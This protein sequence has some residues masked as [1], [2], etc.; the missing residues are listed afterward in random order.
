MG[1][2]TYSYSDRALRSSSLGY[3]TKSAQEIFVERNIN[4]AMNP[5]GVGIRESCDS[6]EHPNSLPI[7]IALDVTGSMGSVPH[8][9]VKEGFP[10]I[11]D[12]IIKSGI[13]DPQVLFL[14]IGDHEC[15]HAPLQVGQ[16]ESSDEL[17][18]K[19]LTSIYLEGGGGGNAGESYLLA[20]YFASY[21]T[22][23]DS[24]EKRGQKGFLFTIGDEPTLFSVPKTYLKK[25]MGEGQYEDYTSQKLLEKA[26]EKYNV[27]HIHIKETGA[28]SSRS[29]M[30]GWK[31][32]MGDEHLIIAN[33][34]EDVADI[35]KNIVIE[36]EAPNTTESKNTEPKDKKD[37]EMML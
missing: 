21:H 37:E 30:N 32:L 3:T 12:S 5:F 22:K 27:Y 19:W 1:G 29:T 13:A 24:F 23:I 7:I 9:L 17:L 31:Q 25:I 26:M 10:E 35:I 14:G 16:F 20:W 36:S 11:M 4:S 18:D 33:K 15:D 34:R 2:G 8:F 6:K 28:G